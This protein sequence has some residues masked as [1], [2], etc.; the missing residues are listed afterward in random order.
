M[1]RVEEVVSEKELKRVFSIRLRVFV[2]EQG[3]PEEIE[4]DKDDQR[5]THFLAR[6]R[7]RA[8]GTA[9]LVIKNR[10]AKIGRMA[11]LK[12]HRGKGAGTALLKRAVEFARESKANMIYLHAQIPV[13]GFYEKM[14]FRCVG[15]IFKE[16][17]IPHCKMVFMR[18]RIPERIRTLS[19]S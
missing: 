16:A 19:R 18:D 7:G 10:R 6:V 4:L 9:R 3:V 14:G 8:V 17:G 5:A 11:V 12:S 2:R 13:I 1:T 15:R